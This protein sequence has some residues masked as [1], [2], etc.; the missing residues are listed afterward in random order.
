MRPY[1]QDVLD[2]AAHRPDLKADDRTYLYVDHALRGVG[3]A[4]CGPGVLE[5]YRLTPRDADF[6][7]T[8]KVRS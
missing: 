4:A 8:L 5:Q 3:T 2:A 7:L 6:S 1:S